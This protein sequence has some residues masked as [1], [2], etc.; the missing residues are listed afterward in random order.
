M[1]HPERENSETLLKLEKLMATSWNYTACMVKARESLNISRCNLDYLL[2]WR[3][4]FL[5]AGVFVKREMSEL[6][7]MKIHLL[8]DV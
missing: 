3:L 4:S 1:Y 2:Q 5:C 7:T 8:P 6:L